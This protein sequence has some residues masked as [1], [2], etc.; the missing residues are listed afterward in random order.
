MT[1]KKLF[2]FDLDGVLVDSKENHFV[3]LNEALKEISPKHVISEIDH[4]TIFEGLP[5]KEKLSILTK[6]KGLPEDLHQKIF[7]LK[8]KKSTEF[9]KNLK[10]DLELIEIFKYI[11]DKDIKIAVASNCIKDT[12][13]VCLESL[14]LLDLVDLYLSN[15]D[16]SNPKPNPEIYIKCMKSFECDPKDVV[17]FEDSYVGK[18]AAIRSK[19]SLVSVD[20]R[21][22]MTKS[23]IENYLSKSKKRI[24][25]LI[26][27]AGEGSRFSKAGYTDPKPFISVN[28]KSMINLVHDNIGIEGRYIFVA[29]S[30]HVN[31]YSLEKHLSNFCSNFII[32]EQGGRLEGATKSALLANEL[33]DNDEPLLIVNSDQHID[34]DA[35]KTIDSFIESGVD[36]S[37]LT[38]KSIEPKWSYAKIKDE[39]VEEVFEK[40]VVGDN[41]TCGVYFW[42]RG[43]DFVKY[44]N[45]MI[46]KNIKTNN[47][48][49]ICPVY[50]QAIKDGKV[51]SYHQVDGMEGLGTPEDLESYLIKRNIFVDISTRNYV[52]SIIEMNSSEFC[53]KYKNP[54]YSIYDRVANKPSGYNRYDYNADMVKLPEASENQE[55]NGIYTWRLHPVVTSLHNSD[56]VQFDN[57]SVYLAAY[58]HRFFHIALEI[59][60]KLFLL[61]ENDPDF[62]LILL[63]DE[64][65][66]EYGDFIGLSDNEMPK[67]K[68]AKYLK[69][70]LDELK[71]D[72]MC[73]NLETLKNFNLNFRS[74]YVFYESKQKEQYA[75]LTKQYS[76]LF[77]NGP[78]TYHNSLPYEPFCLLNRE[79]S[80]SD[81]K[82]NLYLKTCID[83]HINNNY[84]IDNS[85][86]KKIYVS[87]KNYVRSHP[88]EKNIEEYF[89]SKG[90]DSVY[91]EDLNPIEQIELIR[92]SSDI[93]C[94]LGSSLVN[95][96]FTN[97]LTNLTVLSLSS[98]SDENFNRDMFK[99]YESMIDGGYVKSKY[100]NLPEKSNA[101][102]IIDILSKEVKS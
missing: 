31:K 39:I 67:E 76:K 54:S 57:R 65:I 98:D 48:F 38:F 50:N 82:T 102:E 97:R 99:Y 47:E 45:R 86:N 58:N 75:H 88:E 100:I 44:A 89:R 53:V 3:S 95:L 34:W 41:A 78:I 13:K 96:Y 23:F 52:E 20:N 29:K 66:N 73:V 35:K 69:Y 59:L 16:V 87:R 60:P 1:S 81:Y 79:D 77:F 4:K 2:I 83:N 21:S 32:I 92:Q 101:D 6:S 94:Y 55:F 42:K 17:I 30:D 70:W 15:E 10:N 71:I 85:L 51:I 91:I 11:K 61:K 64:Q 5:T 12:V 28:N 24:N 68:D 46:E 9:F 19:A 43:S 27:M 37:I 33:I 72:Y 56:H 93:V 26:P 63:G 62:K 22:T 14:G 90:Y 7:D 25:I 49:Y 36:G 84:K 40:I 74:S 8:Q 18:T 80:T